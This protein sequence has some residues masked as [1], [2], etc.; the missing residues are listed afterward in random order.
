MGT[1]IFAWLIGILGLIMIAGGIWG[2][3]QLWNQ[4]TR[5]K[6]PLRYYGMAFGM[7]CGGFAMIGIARALYLLLVLVWQ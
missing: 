3:I 7:A 2:F 5:I 6:I 1:F 4:R